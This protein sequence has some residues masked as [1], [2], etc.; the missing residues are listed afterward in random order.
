MISSDVS[1]THRIAQ[2]IRDTYGPMK[3]NYNNVLSH[4]E[5]K[6]KN[7]DSLYGHFSMIDDYNYDTFP[8]LLSAHPIQFKLQKGKSLHIPKNWWHWVK[9]TQKTFAINY[10]FNNKTKQEPFIFDHTIDCDINLLNDEIVSVWNSAKK[11]DYNY[12][13][14]SCEINFNEFYNSGKDDMC[15]ITLSNY[16]SGEGNSHIKNNY[17]IM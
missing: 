6:H 4:N 2:V 15:V 1:Y 9:T 16:D 13:G 11:Y 12:E 14:P 17:L 3:S 7:S 8:S 5:Y 10:W